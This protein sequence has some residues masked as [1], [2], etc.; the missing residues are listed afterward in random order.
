M[1]SRRTFTGRWSVVF[2]ILAG[3]AGAPS[4]V[5][6]QSTALQ[7]VLVLDN[8]NVLAGAIERVGD[9]YVINVTGATLQV[10]V[11]QVE[12]FAPTV[13]EAYEQRRVTLVDGT[14]DRHLELAAWCLHLKLFDQAARELLDARRV[15]AQIPGLESLE[16]QLR[17]RLDLEASRPTASHRS[18]APLA[19]ADHREGDTAPPLPAIS[20]EAQAQFVRSIQPM[21]IR[22]CSTAGCHQTSADHGM[23]LDRW[24]LEGRGSAEIVRKNL[25]AVLAEVNIENLGTSE[26]LA[27]A[28]AKHGQGTA[29]GSRPLSAH[30]LDLLADWLHLSLGV[31]PTDASM[32]IASSAEV[33]IE[34]I[35]VGDA[36]IDFD[37]N[38]MPASYTP[39]DA[40]DPEILNRRRAAREAAEAVD[41]EVGVDALN[42]VEL[43]SKEE[44]SEALSS[45]SQWAQ[46]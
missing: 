25:S 28:R 33:G 9:Q 31:P 46:P 30:Q 13:E 23:Q 35:A 38:V 37:P 40:F 15:D 17:H 36:G 41:A 1:L 2:A 45:P 4:V 3:V 18:A 10:P 11:A 24:A 29:G 5:V 26:L 42:A 8:G 32:P 6:A 43:S 14:A 22:N 20:V 21:L 12:R 44:P 34:N 27:K 39:R 19:Q 16:R 7:G